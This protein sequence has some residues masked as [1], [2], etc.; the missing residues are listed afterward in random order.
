MRAW[1]AGKNQ[2]G[3]HVFLGC[4]LLLLD[5]PDTA[6]AAQE[7]RLAKQGGENVALLEPLLR[8]PIIR[9]AARQ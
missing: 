5:T 1:F 8:D 4:D 7:W 2:P 3:N 9:E 6:A